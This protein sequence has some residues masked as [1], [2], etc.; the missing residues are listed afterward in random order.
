[1]HTYHFDLKGSPTGRGKLPDIFMRAIYNSEGRYQFRSY[2]DNFEGSR[3]SRVTITATADDT[4]GTLTEAKQVGLGLRQQETDSD[5]VL[6]Y[7]D[8]NVLHS[9]TNAV[10]ANEW[11]RE[12]LLEGTYYVRIEAREAGGRD[13]VYRYGCGT[14]TRTRWPGSRQCWSRA[15]RR[16]SA[17]STFTAARPALARGRTSP[18]WQTTFP[19][20]TTPRAGSTRR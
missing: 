9:G 18:N 3:K 4:G 15:H 10:T 12:T 2:N 8:G 16:R 5:L 20:S 17:R 13:Y 11:V 1:M 19:S 7:A 6:E 14:R